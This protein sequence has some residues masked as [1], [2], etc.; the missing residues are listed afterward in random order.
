MSSDTRTVQREPVDTLVDDPGAVDS[1]LPDDVQRVESGEN[2]KDSTPDSLGKRFLQ[3]RT[4]ISFVLAAFI[5]YFVFRRLEI[6][7]D[8][9]WREMRNADP[10]LLLAALTTY[11]LAILLRSLRWRMMLEQV[12][13]NEKQGFR[14]PGIL[15]TFQIMVLSLFANC[16]VPARLGDAY[17][18]FL[19]KDR[20]GSS[21]GVG[22]GTI[23][24]ERLID[25]VVMIGLV[26]T[27]GAV[28][29]GT[30]VP[31]KAEQAFL[32]GLVVVVIGIVGSIV[33]FFYH[34]HIERKIPDRFSGHFRRL[35]QG[36]FDILRKPLPF[37]A[38]GLV[39]WLMD[40]LR[41][42]LVAMS[43]GANLSIAEATVVS[44]LSAMVTIIP[45]TPAGLGVVEG[46]MIWILVQVGVEQDTA[47]AIAIL[48]RT[49][50]Y[51][52]LI[53]VGLPM[54]AFH[55]RRSVIAKPDDPQPVQS[56]S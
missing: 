40:G 17:R 9:V 34:E 37:A 48:D 27:A 47:A 21:F 10:L 39:V 30:N 5:V 24:A 15:G 56:G 18:S 19:L 2:G 46:F 42:Y 55:L 13:I 41:V 28:V 1:S 53:V 49:I 43:L 54:Y 12:G 31:G 35:N 33:L 6:N 16:V 45:I 7:I 32:L 25:L 8:D 20:T 51:L 26:V 52:S 11:Y 4:L 44:L 38:L 29:F 3:P 14:L 22:L 50:T 36:I 23:L